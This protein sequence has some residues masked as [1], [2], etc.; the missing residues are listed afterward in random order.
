MFRP[1]NSS[2]H[3]QSPQSSF[4]DPFSATSVITVLKSPSN[5]S[6]LSS[7]CT[8]TLF[9]LLQKERNPNFFIFKSLRTLQKRVFRQLLYNQSF[10]HSFAKHPEC[11]GFFNP[12]AS[13]IFHSRACAHTQQRPQPLSLQPFTSQFSVYAYFVSHPPIFSA[14]P[15]KPS[16][17]AERRDALSG[18]AF[19]HRLLRHDASPLEGKV[20]LNNE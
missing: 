10:P 17:A 19:L 9:I 18:S 11:T 3:S 5:T 12:K 20:G 7:R 14:P 15:A 1:P 13:H 6:S 4:P 8:L 16:A 2:T